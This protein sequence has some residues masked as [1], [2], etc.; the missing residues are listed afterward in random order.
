MRKNYS[1]YFNALRRIPFEKGPYYFFKNTAPFFGRNF[2]QTFTL[3]YT[4]DFMKDKCS[5]L[6]RLMDV[7]YLPSRM[8]V[9]R[10]LNIHG[11]CL[12]LFMGSHDK[13]ISRFLAENKIWT[14]PIQTKII[15]KQESG[16]GITIWIQFIPRILQ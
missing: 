2:F 7:P 13:R 4:Y 6:W 16:Y 9:A 3:F 12:H 1:S 11:L 8:F 14:L 15:E 10:L 5:C